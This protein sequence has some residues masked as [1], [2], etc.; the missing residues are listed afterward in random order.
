MNRNRCPLGLAFIAS[1]AAPWASCFAQGDPCTDFYAAQIRDSQRAADSVF[2]V[3][4][5][6]TTSNGCI[7]GQADWSGLEPLYQTLLNPA[8][9]ETDKALARSQLWPLV[10][11]QF[12]GADSR[13]CADPLD[14]ACMVGRHIAKMNGLRAMLE[15]SEVDR[16]DEVMQPNSWAIQQSPVPQIRI[17]DIRLQA[18]PAQECSGGLAQARCQA[19]VELTAKLMRTAMV[20]NNIIAAYNLPIIDAAGQFLSLRDK[21]WDSYLNTISVQY[22]WELGWNSRRYTRKNAATLQDFPRAPESKII[23]LH[24]SPGYE[25]VEA[26]SGSNTQQPAVIVE[27][28]GYERWEWEGGAAKNRWGA[29]VVA[30]YATIEGM[31]DVGYGIMV[32]T[33]IKNISFGLLRRDGIAGSETGVLIN[34]NLAQFIKKYEGLDLKGFLMPKN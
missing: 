1:L 22:P 17:S 11:A 9:P 5:T 12:A 3:L 4:N 20:M 32:H 29:S 15:G 10:L 30:S 34:L 2:A 25:L 6:Q 7:L 26:P 33:P 31:D 28:I 14:A 16:S 18:F 19:A 8:S 23:A 13:E 27:L 21:E 24:P